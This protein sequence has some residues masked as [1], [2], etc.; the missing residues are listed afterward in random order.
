[1][2]PDGSGGFKVAGEHPEEFKLEMDNGGA[3]KLNNQNMT[4][5]FIFCLFDTKFF[6][7]GDC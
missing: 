7:Y 2:K 6:S 3:V 5:I 1:M 4:Y